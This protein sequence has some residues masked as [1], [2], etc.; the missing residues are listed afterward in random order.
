MD[1]TKKATWGHL[2]KSHMR[3]FGLPINRDP[4]KVDL[5]CIYF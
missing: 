5:L 3:K 4:S 1:E 2:V